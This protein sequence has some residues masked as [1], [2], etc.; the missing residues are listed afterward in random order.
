MLL[1]ESL[2]QS[3][4][5]TTKLFLRCVAVIK[6]LV[7]EVNLAMIWGKNYNISKY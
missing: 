3:D 2:N 4:L 5:F 1:G 7:K 6:P